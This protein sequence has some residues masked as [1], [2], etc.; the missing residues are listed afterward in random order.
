MPDDDSPPGWL[1]WVGSAA[2][3]GLSWLTNWIEQPD[4]LKRDLYADKE[5]CV[6][7]WGDES[8]CEQG[9]AVR[10]GTGRLAYYYG[11]WYGPGQHG[12]SSESR[13]EGTIDSARPGSHAVGTAHVTRGGFGASG[14]AHSSSGS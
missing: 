12:S 5:D 2:V 9:P 11:P 6:K 7:D 4:A 10:S 14:A 3:A 1:I 8:N 13:P